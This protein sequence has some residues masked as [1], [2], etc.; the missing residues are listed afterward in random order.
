MIEQRV[1]GALQ[2]SRE[3]VTYGTGLLDYFDKLKSDTLERTKYADYMKGEFTEAFSNCDSGKCVVE[4]LCKKLPDTGPNKGS[5]QATWT[6]LKGQIVSNCM[7]EA[8]R[9]QDM[10]MTG[11]TTSCEFNYVPV[12]YSKCNSTS[13]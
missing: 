9:F 4:E 8:W 3:L 11:N 7:N 6:K 5:T 13:N 12:A 1:Y 10:I 2:M